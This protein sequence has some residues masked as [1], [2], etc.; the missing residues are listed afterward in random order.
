MKDKAREHDPIFKFGVQVP[1]DQRE[2][3]KLQ[4]R[5]EHN[6]WTDAKDLERSQV[7]EYETFKD[8]S[9]GGL[10]HPGLE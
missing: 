3:C 5:L 4:G 6:N 7:F 8:L 9:K 2:A 10:L 1:D